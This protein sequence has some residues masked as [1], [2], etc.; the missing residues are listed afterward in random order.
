MGVEFG[1]VGMVVDLGDYVVI[2]VVID[3]DNC[4]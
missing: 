2:V 3:V 1:I 4:R